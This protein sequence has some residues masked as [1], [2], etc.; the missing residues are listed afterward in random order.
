MKIRID[1]SIKGSFSVG[2]YNY[3]YN[4]NPKLLPPYMVPSYLVFNDYKSVL[5]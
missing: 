2:T 1:F 5:F 3:L 4:Y